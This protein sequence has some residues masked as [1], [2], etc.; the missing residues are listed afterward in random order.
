MHGGADRLHA[1][2][3]GRRVALFSSSL[4]SKNKESPL[5]PAKNTAQHLCPRTTQ[6]G[7][8]IKRLCAWNLKEEEERE[9]HISLDTSPP[10]TTTTTTTT[11]GTK[12]IIKSDRAVLGVPSGEDSGPRLSAETCSA[13]LLSKPGFGDAPSFYSCVSGM[14]L[15]RNS[16]C[17]LFPAAW[18]SPACTEVCRVTVA[19][20]RVRSLGL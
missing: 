18:S 17:Q 2:C 13:W 4:F 5:S 10:P 7:T 12:E 16:F 6:Q 8:G 14:C 20:S 3:Q 1:R 11:T 9:E 15:R 19:G